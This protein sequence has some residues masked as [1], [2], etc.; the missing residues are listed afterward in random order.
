MSEAR[1]CGT[2]PIQMPTPHGTFEVRAWRGRDGEHMSLLARGSAWPGE[3]SDASQPPLVR[4]HSECA[5]GDI[6]GSYRCDC[7]E[8]LEKALETIQREG[9]AVIYMRGHEGRGIGLF[10]K[11]RA[12]HLQDLGDDTV[13]ANVHLGLPVD[14]RRYDDAADILR[15]LGMGRVRLMTN[16]PEKDGALAGLGIEVAEIVPSVIAPRGANRR[17]LETKREKM[18]HRLGPSHD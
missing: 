6:F 12:Y 16:N 1:V 9:G 7:G 3:G 2:E 18:A 15:A 14:A 5:T 13:E 8:Q 11:I 17:Y 10:E 4:V